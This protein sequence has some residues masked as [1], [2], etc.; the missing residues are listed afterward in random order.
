M[1]KNG[2]KVIEVKVGSLD[3]LRKDLNEVFDDPTRVEKESDYTIYLS[4][5]EVPK[6]FSEERVRLIHEI[7]KNDYSVT[8]LA[9]KL[10]RRRE[11]VSRD[12]AIL[13]HFGLV[14]VCKIGREKHP[15]TLPEIVI[16]L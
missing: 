14:R 2:K 5:D 11:N 12:L 16:S 1:K 7:R 10:K 9:S 13:E 4:P 8:Q 6:L 15:K 3:D